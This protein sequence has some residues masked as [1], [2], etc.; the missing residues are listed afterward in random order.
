M[1]IFIILNIWKLHIYMSIS[2]SNLKNIFIITYRNRAAQK[3]VFIHHMKE[4]LKDQN[5]AMIFVHQN[6]E[7]LFNKG[8]LMNIGFTYVRDKYPNIYKNLNFTF[9]DIDVMPA[10]KNQIPYKTIKGV[11]EHHYG[12]NHSIGGI[13]TFNGEDYETINGT[14][15][16]WGWGWEDNAVHLRLLNHGIK[17]AKNH[18]F[19]KLEPKTLEE[20][21]EINTD[22][23]RVFNFDHTKNLLIDIKKN[24]SVE[25]GINS[26][27]NVDYDIER[28]DE[29]IIMLHVNHFNTL[30]KIPNETFFKEPPPSFDK[31][32]IMKKKIKDRKKTKEQNAKNKNKVFNMKIFSK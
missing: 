8:A 20:F 22:K 29:K 21:I 25:Y 17:I 30:L 7:R 1:Y 12:F 27:S 31:Y 2:K 9:H 6:D 32:E 16:F 10:F 3:E 26:L 5:Y 4:V 18:F 19:N 13:Y 14:P 15:N 23:K 28:I 11:V 24:N